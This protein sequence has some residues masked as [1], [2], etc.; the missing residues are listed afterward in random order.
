MKTKWLIIFL[1]F[2]ILVG[3]NNSESKGNKDDINIVE[4]NDSSSLS[5]E[6]L[7]PDNSGHTNKAE[8]TDGSSNITKATVEEASQSINLSYYANFIY[9]FYSGDPCYIT[10]NSATDNQINFRILAGD[11]YLTDDKYAV[12]ENCVGTLRGDVVEFDF[13]DNYNNKGTGTLKFDGDHVLIKTTVEVMNPDADYSLK[14]ESK[15]DRIETFGDIIDDPTFIFSDS[16]RRYL[17]EEELVKL[18]KQDLEY[19]RNEIYARHGYIFK[20]PK[21]TSYFYK[22]TWYDYQALSE[23]FT[24][25]PSAYLNDYEIKNIELIKKIENQ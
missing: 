17:N 3:C 10:F 9:E 15:L 6:I 8:K 18:S 22:K 14:V 5:D 24:D 4:T 20:S 13:V 12:A 7:T 16:D 2:L 23:E 25:N 1:T 21:Y 19:A 11:P